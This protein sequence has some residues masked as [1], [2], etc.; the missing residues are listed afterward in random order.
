MIEER[1]MRDRILTHQVEGMYTDEIVDMFIGLEDMVAHLE[2]LLNT[3]PD[4]S[5]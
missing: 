3:V 4:L 5:P 1:V 2:D